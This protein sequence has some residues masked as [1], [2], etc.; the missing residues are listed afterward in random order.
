MLIE[1]IINI[2]KAKSARGA[3]YSPNWLFTC[4]LLYIRGPKS[5]RLIRELKILPLSCES[6]VHRYLKSSNTGVGFD[7]DF[8]KL[9]QKRI[10]FLRSK[11]LNSEHGTLCFDEMQVKTALDVNIKTMSF[12]GLVDY[13]S[14]ISAEDIEK[15]RDDKKLK[16]SKGDTK[17]QNSSE[18]DLKNEQADH[19]L[20][21]M[22]SSLTASFHQPIGVFATRGAAPCQIMAKLI[23]SA[24]MAIE[25]H[26]GKVEAIICDGAQNNRGL[27][28]IFGIQAKPVKDKT[29]SNND[30]I[31]CS[32]LNPLTNLE[33]TS[34]GRKIYVISDVP[35][36][37]KCIRNNL[38]GNKEKSFEV[39]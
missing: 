29:K 25:K 5:Y 15:S 27:W 26:G 24:V 35:H 31:V 11:I 8:F 21:F 17:T 20:V 28:K 23:I 13:G 9:F 3:R 32:F 33:N 22:F 7:D 39:I 10:D 14:T 12:D 6:T 19:A 18:D 30:E 4:L 1:E 34:N 16:K 36:L 38:V 37:F 2:S